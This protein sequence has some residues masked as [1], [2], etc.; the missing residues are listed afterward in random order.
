MNRRWF[1]PWERKDDP[2]KPEM[3]PAKT[4]VSLPDP[5]DARQA[6]A[7][8][9]E[10]KRTAE[11]LRVEMRQ[12]LVNMKRARERNHFAEAILEIIREGK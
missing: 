10:G 2:P 11:Q 3:P 4:E 8:S 5:D 12:T 9:E 7:E 1:F 6:L